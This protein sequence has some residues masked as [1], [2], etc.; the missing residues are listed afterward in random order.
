MKVRAVGNRES[1][2]IRETKVGV[3][4]KCMA[5]LCAFL[6][7]E[8]ALTPQAIAERTQLPLPTVYRLAQALTEQG[9]LEHEGQRF[10]LGTMLMRLGAAAADGIDLR[11]QALPHLKWLNEQ[12]EE[13][14]ELQVRRAET[15]VE[16]ELVRSP[17]NLR[18]FVEV[19]AALPLH[20]GAAGKALLAWLPQQEREALALASSRRFGGERPF[21][22]ARLERELG[23]VRAMGCAESEGE[24]TSGVSALAAPI[25]DASGQ[26]VGA[27]TLAAPSM[28]LG[29][30]RRRRLM[31]LVR[32]A[33]LR[34]SRVIGYG[35]EYPGVA[36]EAAVQGGPA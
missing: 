13:N 34:T 8:H 10:R 23:R 30:E 11:H 15:R 17:H 31:P 12:T 7:G 32:E 33:A 18:P 5:V 20:V 6:E 14:A 16:I 35:G 22:L 2:D 28:R 9:M 27:V 19:G 4:D 1:A 26:V 25:L 24:R 29:P 3:L 21:V 36:V